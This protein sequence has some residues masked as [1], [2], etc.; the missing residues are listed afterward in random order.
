MMYQ[1]WNIGI[2]CFACLTLFA[3]EA[4]AAEPIATFQCVERL[5]LDWAPTLLTYR[6]E[7]EPGQA[8]P[9]NVRLLDAAG[10]E[11]PVQLSRMRK[12]ADG[13]IASARVSFRAGLPK[14]GR[15]SFRL[16]P[17]K[18][19]VAGG[20]LTV[21]EAAQF[22]TID[23][24]ATALRL[25]PTGDHKVDKPLRFGNDQARM[26]QLYGKQ[27]QNGVIPGPIRGFRLVDG[28]WAGGSYLWAADSDKAPKLQSW[29][30]KVIESGPLFVDTR[31]R[32]DFE[33]GKYYQVTA[34][35]IA[36]DPALRIDEQMDMGPPADM[37]SLRAVFSLS[38]GWRE[39]GWKP[40]VAY[41]TTVEGRLGGKAEKLEA[42]AAEMGLEL[43][44]I[45]RENARD[46][47]SRELSYDNQW[48]KVCDTAVWYPWHPNAYY[49]GLADTADLKP[50]ADKATVPFVGVVP[51]H[52]GNWRGA[53]TSANGM[54]FT[55]KADDVDLHWPL[56]AAP[57]PNSLLHTGEYDPALPLS[58]LRRQWAIIAGPMQYHKGLRRF[59]AYDGYVN[60][61]DYKDWV[62]DWPVDE[63][64]TYPRLVFDR[65]LV[66]DLKGRLADHPGGEVLKEFLYFNDNAERCQNLY[67]GL[68]APE[69]EWG[70]PLGVVR[71]ALTRAAWITGYRYSQ[72]CNWAGGVDELL[73]SRHLTNEQRRTVRAHL[74]ALCSMM[75]EPD[76]NPRGAMVHLG[77]PNMP[78]NR[79]LG[80]PFTAALIPDHPRA[81]EWL[82][83]SADYVR[84]KLAM[85][86]APG[87][88][89]SELISYYMGAASHIMQASLVLQKS[90]RL[91]PQVAR[92]AAGAGM[93]PLYLLAPRDPRFNARVLPG[94][95]HEGYWM[96]PTQWLPVAGFMRELDPVLARDMAW[97]WD[98]LGQPMEDH[99][100][101]GFSERTVLHSDLLADLPKGY[102]P[103][104][105]GSRWL[106]GFGA[107]MRAHAG[108]PDEIYMSYRQGYLTSHSDANQGD[109]VIHAKGATLTN[110][111][112]Y[113]YA[114]HQDP[115]Y[116]KLYE[117]FGW[118]NRV[119]F[120]E[121]S[122]TGGWP[123]GRSISNVHAFASGDSVDYL[124]ALGDYRPQRW[125]RQVLLVKSKRPEATSYFVFKD[126]F[127][128]L[129]GQADRLQRKWWYMSTDGDKA[130]VATDTSGMT[131]TSASGPQLH[132]R[133]LDPTAV[134][135]ESRHETRTGPM[136]NRAAINWQKAGSP[137]VSGEG[138]SLQVEETTTVTAFGPIAPGQDIL[139][140]LVPAKANEKL[141]DF[142]MLPGGALRVTTSESTDY[143]FS[144]R[145]ATTIKADGI[146]FSGLAGAVR[147]F[148]DEVHLVV[149]EG[150]G[151][152]TYKGTTLRSEV[153]TTKVIPIA[154][155]KPGV[156]EVAAPADDIAFELNRAGAKAERVRGGVTKHTF[157]GG[158]A[159]EFSAAG[160]ITFES[161]GVKFLGRTG[162]IV[163]D[164][165]ARTT[166]M[167]VVDGDSMSHGRLRTW[168]AGG[169]Y[170]VTFHKD[171]ITGRTAGLG[172][173]LYMTRPEGL[174]RLPMYVLDGQ[175]YAP[176]TRRDTLIVPI[177]PGEHEFEIRPLP[178]PPVWRN[179]QAWE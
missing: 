71:F 152:L 135:A 75:S 37:W 84:Y 90:G 69:G 61:D 78:I 161:D 57:H 43:P 83:V 16:L 87:D 15:Y 168:Q 142:E 55:H 23:N 45:A 150:P 162:G 13:S 39:G 155:L 28:T 19:Q 156:V 159:Y 68:T 70:S 111:S 92:L 99:H 30:C 79:F 81:N 72:R 116:K 73:A 98:Q 97:G 27:A 134:Q 33:G 136:Y 133:F 38:A 128:N 63:K 21:D 170:D 41:W 102:V 60:L 7:L 94:W 139:V 86:T 147:V 149:S 48:E 14:D 44:E 106:P 107:T 96:I 65:E 64:V 25:P 11:H 74:A 163:V 35:V 62:L 22:L 108:H 82:D 110:L 104:R 127:H 141:P 12:H 109:F 89:W 40:D 175:T 144:C 126:S 20:K 132:V 169:P 143:V 146:V 101:A 113:Q 123:G 10:K 140:A 66:D 115:K 80:L 52:A 176:G 148:P 114:I 100:D 51:M 56:I 58:F 172:R 125:T 77:N 49:M 137:V 157:D 124:R 31:I 160:R 50:D 117:D 18:P 4:V 131:Y 32:Y 46:F 6:V 158:F 122:N 53:T 151:T 145:E 177:M 164:E 1:F 34:R 9:N 105:I 178:Q 103:R 173:F 95:G 167:V 129:D 138:T 29:S 17:E 166:R 88:A 174:D 2:V 54:L 153:P 179:W 165:K 119:R 85:N 67:G 5:Q 47:G 93:F 91:D 76:F 42:A 130:R 26:V 154:D 171:R 59:R 112:L 8:Q 120:G 24:G 36:N 3:S 118:H 121:Q